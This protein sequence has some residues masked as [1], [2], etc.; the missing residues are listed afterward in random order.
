M[1]SN[2]R[3]DIITNCSSNH[4]FRRLTTKKT[5]KL[6]ITAHLWGGPYSF[7]KVSVIRKSC[8]CYDI[9]VVKTFKKTKNKTYQSITLR[10][11]MF[12]S[13]TSLLLPRPAWLCS[14]FA[15]AVAS[16]TRPLTGKRFP[17]VNGQSSL[18]Y[19]PPSPSEAPW[20]PG[21][22]LLVAPHP[23]PETGNKIA[24]MVVTVNFLI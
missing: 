9:I 11:S 3:N 12:T 5:P 20:H 8:P 21:S 19:S 24:T 22:S 10:F 13:L 23:A 15:R 2:N 7:H 17:L 6:H 18:K 16:V 14:T 4:L 1:T